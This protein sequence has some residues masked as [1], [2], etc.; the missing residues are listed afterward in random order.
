MATSN[1]GYGGVDYNTAEA[2]L[3]KKIAQNQAN[4]ASNSAYKDSETQRALQVI[5]QREAQGLDTSAQQ[6]YLT[7]NLGYKAPTPANPATN[8]NTNMTTS[9]ATTTKSNSQQGSDLMDLMRQIASR[10]TTP[11]N[12]DAKSDPAY[13]AALQR[14]QANI[15]QGNSAAQA[16]MNRRNILNSTITSDRM[17]EIASQEMGRVETDVLPS[18]MQQAYQKYLDQE[19]M[20]Q[21]QFANYGSLAQMYLNEDQRG[22]ENEFALSDRTGYIKGG[23]QAQSLVSQLMSLKQQAETPGITAAERTKLSNQADG[24]RA[25]LSGM[26]VDTSQ[27]GANANYSTASQYTPMIRTLAGQQLDQA[28][29]AQAFEQNFAQEQFAYQ[30]IRD[31]IA[32][33][34]WKKEFDEDSR[35]FGLQYALSRQVQL[36]GLS[37]DRA[38]L[39]LS[40]AAQENDRL[41]EV[42]KATGKAPEGIK[43]VAAGTQY[44]TQ[45]TTASGVSEKMMAEAQGMV[46]SVREGKY[47]PESAYKQIEEDTRL[48]FYTAPEAQY[49]KSMLEQVSRSAPKVQ[50]PA[51]AQKSFSDSLPTDKEIYK[52]WETEGKKLGAAKIDFALW[53]KSPQGRSAGVDFDTWKKLYGPTMQ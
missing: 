18:L 1:L 49:L 29:Q 24:I 25:M 20:K 17:G 41:M 15:D 30:K 53:Y 27:Y 6:K 42:W 31:Q 22:I 21:Q 35:R 36:G 46:Q 2:E 38:R 5:A 28:K 51:E 40:Q 8:T 13:Q 39:A 33:E 7:Q 43:G 45:P 47:T 16:E 19:N 26:G 4:I 12:Y 14:A 48:G 11:F 32:D 9:S 44:G 52:I 50:I 23:E 3:K 37:I 10:E 34:K